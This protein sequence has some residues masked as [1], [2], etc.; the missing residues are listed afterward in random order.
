VRAGAGV[1]R[2]GTVFAVRAA[3]RRTAK[4]EVR[5]TAMKL[6]TAKVRRTAKKCG[7]ATSK[8]HGKEM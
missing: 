5:R 8:T 2:A 3:R 4:V 7:T 1:V 6:G